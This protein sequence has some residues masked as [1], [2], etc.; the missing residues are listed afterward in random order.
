MHGVEVIGDD[1]H[2][3][4]CG[5]LGVDQDRYDK[6]GRKIATIPNDEGWANARLI[7]AAPE[8]LSSLIDVVGWVLADEDSLTDTERQS[9][10]RARSVI[11]QVRGEA[12]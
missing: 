1:G 2:R 11:A 9:L 8:L 12:Q 4:V 10:I 5:V 7:A 6:D 3:K